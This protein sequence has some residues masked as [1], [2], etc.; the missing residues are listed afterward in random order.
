MINIWVTSAGASPTV[1]IKTGTPT[2][3]QVL[4]WKGDITSFNKTGGSQQSEQ[5]TCFGGNQTIDKP[6][7]AYELAFEVY[8]TIETL[9]RWASI[10][11]VADTTNAGTY[12]CRALP[13]DKTVFVEILSGTTYHSYAFNN[14]NITTS[15]DTLNSEDGFSLA[16]NA[17]VPTDT[18]GAPNYMYKKAA[19]TSLPA[20]SALQKV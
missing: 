15:D 7:T 20:W 12:T 13:G 17:V 14:A 16:L 8:P 18:A 19:V 6:R 2:G 5:R 1:C 9:D 10:S 4:P 11:L 3:Q